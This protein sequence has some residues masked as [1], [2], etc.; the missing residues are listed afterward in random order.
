MVVTLQEQIPA[1][2]SVPV[3]VLEVSVNDTPVSSI[4]RAFVRVIGFTPPLKI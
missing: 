3:Q 4:I 2:G 1:A